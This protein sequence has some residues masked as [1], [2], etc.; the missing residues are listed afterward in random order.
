M[1]LLFVKSGQFHQHLTN[2]CLKTWHLS[3]PMGQI[4]VLSV[5]LDTTSSS[6]FHQHLYKPWIVNSSFL[7]ACSS[8]GPTSRS[9]W[10]NLVRICKQNREQFKNTLKTVL[11]C[12]GAEINTFKVF[13]VYFGN[14]VRYQAK[15][16]QFHQHFQI[17]CI[18]GLTWRT[19]PWS[20]TSSSRCP[21]CQSCSTSSGCITVGKK[22]RWNR[23]QYSRNINI[24]TYIITLIPLKI[25]LH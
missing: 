18:S 14:F 16:S 24:Y 8:R 1:T 9:W 12:S 10:L 4:E 15:K 11:A 5:F 25:Y 19:Q 23:K 7:W 17:V 21:T 6:Q 20:L 2:R 13:T 22:S 3:W